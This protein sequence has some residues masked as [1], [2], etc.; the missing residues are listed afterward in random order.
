MGV[1]FFL[2]TIYITVAAVAT[3]R[4]MQTIANQKRNQKNFNLTLM[5]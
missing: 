1:L 3:R 2:M 4:Q 5:A